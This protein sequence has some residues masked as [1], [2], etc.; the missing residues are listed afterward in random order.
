MAEVA[1]AFVSIMPSARGFGKNLE[2]QVAPEVSKSGNRITGFLGKSMKAGV[3]GVGAAVGGALGTA[4][5]KGFD[6]L[7]GIEQAEAKLTGLGHSAKSV[8][9]IMS[10]ALASV[11]GTAF[12]LQEAATTAAGA[13]A[14]G[15]QPGEQLERTLKLVGDA[16]TIAGTDMGSMGAIF[17]KVAASDMIQGDVLA[18]LGDVGIPIL[19]LLGKQMGVSA[20]EVRNLAS[21]GKIDFATFQ[22]AMEQGLGGA[23]LESGNT[24][25]G[26]FKNMQASLGRI[27]ANLLSGIFPQIRGGFSSMTSVLSSIEPVAQRVGAAIGSFLATAIAT[28]VPAIQNFVTGMRE[29]T[30]AGGALVTVAQALAAALA[31]AMPTVTAIFTFLANNKAAV[32][33]FAGTILT[34][35]A[36]VRI[37]AAAQAALNVVLAANPIGIVVVAIAALAA[38]LVM[39]YQRSATFRG[40]VQAVGAAL[41]VAAGFVVEISR[42][43]GAFVA[44]VAG[45]AIPAVRSFAAFM[46]GAYAGA[47]RTAI[48]VIGNI[49]GA[50][51]RFGGALIDGIQFAAR[52]AAGVIERGAQV[53]R[54]FGELPGKIVGV[55]RGLAST[56]FGVGADIVRGLIS[57]I[58]SMAASVASAAANVVKGAIDAAKSALKIKS[59]SRVFMEIG[60]FT[61]QGL[62]KGFANR[63]KDA[64]NAMRF[65]IKK[66]RTTSAADM[67]KAML[68]LRNKFVA[69]MNDALEAVRGAMEKKRDRIKGVLDGFKSDFASLSSSIAQTFTG[70]LFDVSAIEESL[71]DTKWTAAQS[72]SQAFMNNLLDKRSELRGLSV[73]FKKLLGW[74]MS[75]QFLSQLFQSGNGAL[76]LELA[77]SKSQAQQAQSVFGEVQ[78][79]SA[80][81]GNQVARAD[82]GPKIDATNRRLERIERALDRLPK[83]FGN[84]LKAQ[85]GHGQRSAK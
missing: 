46:V 42:R 73:A 54:W 18:Q 71:T 56:L 67:G 59:P 1:S 76:I 48:G 64:V 82:I 63:D 58:Q 21:K 23:A 20:T 80:S 32:A 13:V 53:V 14:A 5:F 15:V 38:G 7:Q 39:A 79:L 28:I 3:I 60:D 52:F 26:A 77:G 49:I 84:E 8:D 81:L 33:A 72:V 19:Q 9:G 22:S 30:G 44:E 6:R 4:L 41:K 74:G 69:G 68:E 62:I 40:I 11:K 55:L 10:N 27:G 35:V 50:L 70:N 65:I 24:M 16:A 47:I 45:R 29:G 57:G 75:P 36:A 31:A 25:S 61:M 85:V 37:W 17:N 78:S 12:G 66:I 2:G 83:S 43:I 51:A 34:V